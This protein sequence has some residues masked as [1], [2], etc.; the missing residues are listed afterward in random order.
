MK[1][2]NKH[3]VRYL[4]VGAYAVIHYTEPRYTK[5]LDIWIEPKGKNAERVYK[6][7]KE[8]GA[9]LKDIRSQDFVNEGLVYQIGVAPVRVDIIM[10]IGGIKFNHA[11]KHRDI[12]TFDGIKLNIIGINELI[13]SKKKAK[14]DM[15]LID[16][17]SLRYRLKIKKEK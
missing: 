17:K 14:R 16:I 9:P 4:V 3:K 15:D 2:L 5:D 13:E 8:F 6:A 11:W 12:T 1:I 7:L 10:G